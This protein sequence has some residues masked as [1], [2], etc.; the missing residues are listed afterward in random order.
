[1]NIYFDNA[2]TT[3]PKPKIVVDSIYN[4]MTNV[5][6]NANR[7]S[8]SNSLETSK[9]LYNCRNKISDF[10]HFNK[11]SNVIFTNNITTSLN[12]L[13]RGIIKEGDHIISST[14]E[15]NSILRPLHDCKANMDIDLTLIPAL[16]TGYVQPCDIENA[17]KPNTKLVI[18]SHASNVTGTIQN[19]EE[20]GLIC[21]RHNIFFIVDSAQSAGVLNVFFDTLHADAIAFTGHKSL[22]GPQGIGGFIISDELNSVCS[23]I[24]SGGTGSESHLLHQP[25][26]LP[27]K[28][29]CGTMNMPGI[30]GLSSSIDYINQIGL[31]TIH[32]K[33]IYLRGTLLEG[34]M[35]INNI[36]VYGDIN[37]SNSTTCI[38]INYKDVDAAELSY[39]LD[40]KGVQTRSGL[41]CAPLAHKTIDTYPTGTLRLS[42]SYNN[43]IDEVNNVL[44]ILNNFSKDNI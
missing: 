9:I 4:Y 31:N 20:I 38:S 32:E 33:L 1:M 35:N 44:K 14:M 16:K 25:D 7:A 41:H 5:G 3:F 26:F 2:S 15:H 21:K 19:L 17:I 11:P 36:Q 22:L 37:N 42:L 43:T 28:F 6:G 29:E 34:L 30:V 40:T 10:F 13:I 27:D 39:Y 23:T 12:I 18:L 8:S 24:I